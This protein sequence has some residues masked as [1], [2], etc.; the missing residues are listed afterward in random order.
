MKYYTSFSNHVLASAFVTQNLLKHKY[1]LQHHL[2]V[3]LLR[4]QQFD[5]R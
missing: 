3:L 5:H 1:D 2:V 4:L